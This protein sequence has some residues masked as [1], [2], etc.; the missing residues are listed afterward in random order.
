MFVAPAK[1]L[2]FMLAAGMILLRTKRYI[3]GRWLVSISTGLVLVLSWGPLGYGLL[4]GLENRFPIPTE[5]PPKLEGIMVLA[6]AERGDITKIRGQ[7]T[8][9]DG[10]ERL[11]AFMSLARRY[12]EAKLLFVGGNGEVMNLNF[13]E[14]TVVL[15]FEQMGLDP[16]R[17]IFESQSRN[18]VEGAINSYKLVNPQKGENWILITSAFHMPRSVGVFRKAGWE[19]IPYPADFRLSDELDFSLNLENLVGF[20]AWFHEWLGILIYWLTGKTSE[21]LPG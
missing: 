3:V 14:K 8:L 7:P 12:P 15:L 6:G 21:F 20:S 2:L 9:N 4:R 10:G 19:V 17:I 18:T 13:P 5:L 11:I 16:A 1:I